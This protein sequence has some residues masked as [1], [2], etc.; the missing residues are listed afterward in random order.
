MLLRFLNGSNYISLFNA[1]IFISNLVK[2]FQYLTWLIR[3]RKAE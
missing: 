2:K 3:V 1:R